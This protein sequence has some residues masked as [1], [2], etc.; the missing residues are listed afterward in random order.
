MDQVVSPARRKDDLHLQRGGMVVVEGTVEP[1]LASPFDLHRLKERSFN[2][3]KPRGH[4][5]EDLLN[6]VGIPLPFT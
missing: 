1:R 5:A 2:S 3:T 6:L 4:Y